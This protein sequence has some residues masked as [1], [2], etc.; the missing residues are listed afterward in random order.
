METKDKRVSVE[1]AQ[2]LYDDVRDR[3]NEKSD[4]ILK[5]V[6][7]PAGI[8]SF[9]DGADGL[10]LKELKVGIE[11]VQDLHGYDHP[12]VGGAGKNLLDL[13]N[14]TYT[15]LTRS[16]E[17]FT[18][19]QTDTRTFFQLYVLGF[20]VDVKYDIKSTGKFVSDSFTSIAE[21][22]T[23]TIKHNGSSTDFPIYVTQA[24]PVGTYKI[25]MDVVSADPTTV[26]GLVIKNIMIIKA[27]ET[28]TSFTPYSNICPISGFD[29]AKITRTGTNLCEEKI[30][31]ANV[32]SNG[33][34][35][36]PYISGSLFLAKV[37]KGKPYIVTKQET[38][39]V[40]GFFTSKP[41]MSS[42]TYN[43]SRTVVTNYDTFTSPIDGWVLVR[44]LID[45]EDVQIELGDT[46]TAYEPFVANDTYSITFPASAGTVY[47]GTLKVNKDGSGELV[48]DKAVKSIGDIS[49]QLDGNTAGRF[50]ATV[51]DMKPCPDS[52]IVY[53][54]T[55][56]ISSHYP[57]SALSKADMPDGTIRYNEQNR[58][59]LFIKN[60]AYSTAE[61][62]KEAMSEATICYPLETV[63]TYALSAPA[64]YTLLGKN[65]VYADTG[66]VLSVTYYSD[67]LINY[68]FDQ[69]ADKASIIFQ[70]DIESP[71][72]IISLPN[73]ADNAPIGLKMKI[74]PVQ[75]LH[76]YD[77]P[78]IG[79]AGKNLWPFGNIESSGEN[80]P[81]FIPAGT[82]AFS[83][84]HS[85][86]S[87]GASAIRFIYS[88]GTYV[89][90]TVSYQNN[91]FNTV[92]LASDVVACNYSTS[93]G[94]LSNVQVEAGTVKTAFEPYSNICPI[95]GFD[96]AEITRTG[97]NLF[98]DVITSNVNI[99]ANGALQTQSSRSATTKGCAVKPETEYILSYKG[100]INCGVF[101]YKENGECDSYLAWGSA[102]RRFTT[103]KN[104]TRVRFS[105]YA[106][107]GITDPQ[108]E[109]GSVISDYEPYT[110]QTYSIVF[111]TS[112]G[113][114]YG[115]ELTVNQ[116]GSGL[117][118][119][120]RKIRMISGS[121]T[122]YSLN[123]TATYY[124]SWVKDSVYENDTSGVIT[125]VLTSNYPVVKKRPRNLE[126]GELVFCSYDISASRD[127]IC[128]KDDMHDTLEAFKEALSDFCIVYRI[129]SVI[130]TISAQTISSL[131]GLNHIWSNTGDILSASYYTEA[132]AKF[133]DLN[134]ATVDE[135]LEIVQL[136]DEEG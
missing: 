81:W 28:D 6:E 20:R 54:G 79:G 22:T 122:W 72:Q 113:T 82:Y 48:V 130:Y 104:V 87:N 110:G 60:S 57:Y 38:N 64:V 131:L 118:T 107:S 96:Y 26:G 58:K 14:A 129:P 61:A 127:V 3:L 83:G 5:T 133:R 95:S 39:M 88:D 89:I 125:D 116:D 25:V 73:A 24:I 33:T 102:P 9:D 66:D 68:E 134:I 101:F 124:T 56:L 111:P 37:S 12:W 35:Y 106:S 47:G 63:I 126:N 97:R 75:D 59:V 91:F 42:V 52:V 100:E 34:I 32:E 84:T 77:K 70:K 119:V 121:D 94:I 78:W 23:I 120:D 55:D 13:S 136:Y 67:N 62:F 86:P 29:H 135:T 51:S 117:L 69:K 128:I 1:G 45:D 108:L 114:V 65:R 30:Y 40:C 76:G 49:W 21:T 50:I 10:P 85:S 80:I 36:T 92:T 31:G 93:N 11:P 46:K 15:K 98:S 90:V 132:Y 2:A 27:T 53:D 105:F 74:D 16:G 18:N 4:L 115:G 7:G 17:T 19:T 41:T 71:A 8:L 99:D 43:H 103:P 112:A 123:N 109:V 44:S